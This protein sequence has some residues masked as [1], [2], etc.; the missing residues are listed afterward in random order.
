MKS[1]IVYFEFP[2]NINESIIR[3]TVVFITLCSFS[4]YLYKKIFIVPNLLLTIGIS[5]IYTNKLDETI[6]YTALLGL[7]V[8]GYHFFRLY[9]I[10]CVES[11]KF[12]GKGTVLAIIASVLG[13]ISTY[14][15]KI[16]YTN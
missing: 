13:Y 16:H 4:F 10:Q 1:N 2:Y 14:H 3:A 8:Y 11:Y 7:I 5:S 12:T 15:Y 9:G 6:L